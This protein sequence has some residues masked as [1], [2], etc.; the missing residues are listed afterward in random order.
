MVFKTAKPTTTN[1]DAAMALGMHQEADCLEGVFAGVVGGGG[2]G[3]LGF[4]FGES[5]VSG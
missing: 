5:R 4:G 3:I 2:G 1:P